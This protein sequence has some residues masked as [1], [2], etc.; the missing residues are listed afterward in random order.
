MNTDTL[1]NNILYKYTMVNYENSVIYKIV[2]RDLS[3]KNNYI[4]STTDFRKIKINHK[5]IN[6]TVIL[7][8]AIMTFFLLNLNVKVIMIRFS[9]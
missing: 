3:I 5:S 1:V 8:I 2:C 7:N 6:F 4:G 9:F